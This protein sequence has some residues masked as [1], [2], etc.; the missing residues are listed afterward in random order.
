MKSF[1]KQDSNECSKATYA[2]F[3]AFLE[4]SVVVKENKD[5]DDLGFEINFGAFQCQK[6]VRFGVS[7]KYRG[8]AFEQHKKLLVDT[9]WN[10]LLSC[11]VPNVFASI[12]LK[13]VSL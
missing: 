13:G 10:D 9:Y 7:Y 2:G 3:I 5:D 1:Q 6:K 8:S 12:G 11:T 4:Q